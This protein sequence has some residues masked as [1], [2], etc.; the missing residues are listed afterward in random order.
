ME[1]KTYPKL[2]LGSYS[3]E[4]RYTQADIREIVEYARLR[5]IR[6]M[7]E[8][9][10][11]GHAGSWCAGYPDICPSPTCTQPLNPANTETF[12]LITKLLSE[13]TGGKEKAG[14]FPETLLHL[15]GDEVDTGC[16]SKSAQISAWM[17]SKNFTA[18]QTYM[19]FVNTVHQIALDQGRDPVAWEEVFNHFGTKLN[20]RTI[21]H[22]WLAFETLAKVVAAGYRTI[23]S[24]QEYWY[25]DHLQTTWQQFYL[26]D[27]IRNINNKTQQ[28]LILGG[29]VCMWGETADAS[30][31]L[32]TVWPRAAAAAERLW[33]D[34]SVNVPADFLPRLEHFR[35]L[36]NRRSVPAAPVNNQNARAA[37]SGP[38][39]C[40]LQ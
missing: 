3:P 8:F 36:L 19:Y 7:P 29:E 38:G 24:N 2:W 13:V 14:L 9:D 20:K 16:W 4:E 21:I 1:S 28:A 6:V 39:S 22:I 26:N 30:D 5:G 35:C 31:V 10:M 27:P 32:Q 12:T 23:L 34:V 18:D 40:Y 11:P 33:S 37:P 17:K 15:G 25:L